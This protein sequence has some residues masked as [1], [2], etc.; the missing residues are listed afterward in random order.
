MLHAIQIDLQG[1]GLASERNFEN[2]IQITTLFNLTK[3]S[4]HISILSSSSLAFYRSL[5]VVFFLSFC[6]LMN[7]SGIVHKSHV[8]KI[9]RRSLVSSVIKE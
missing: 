4:T 3:I 1:I 2:C 6:W 5:F 7:R 9:A 8:L